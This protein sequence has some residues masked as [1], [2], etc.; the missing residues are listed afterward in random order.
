MKERTIEYLAKNLSRMTRE[1][2]QKETRLR[3]DNEKLRNLQEQ[4]LGTLDTRKDA[5]MEGRTQASMDT[6][7]GL[8]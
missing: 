3:D 7:D 6:L 1:A 5:K 4:T 8:I 2:E